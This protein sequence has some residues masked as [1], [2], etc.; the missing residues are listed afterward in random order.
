M[1]QFTEGGRAKRPESD[2]TVHSAQAQE[3]ARR[4]R[5]FFVSRTSSQ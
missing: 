2:T 4:D 5:A 1:Q 3:T